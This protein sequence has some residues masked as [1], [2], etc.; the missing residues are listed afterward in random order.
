[1]LFWNTYNLIVYNVLAYAFF[2]SRP[3]WISDLLLKRLQ[4]KNKQVKTWPVISHSVKILTY[5][6]YTAWIFARHAHPLTCDLRTF[7]HTRKRAAG[8]NFSWVTDCKVWASR[9]HK[10]WCLTYSVFH[11]FAFLIS[12]YTANIYSLNTGYSSNG[13][14][15]VINI[16]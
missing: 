2:F 8:L 1:M 4:A 16:L 6:R 15:L 9:T 7:E 3:Q 10:E 12:T 13:L 5:E 11:P 14:L